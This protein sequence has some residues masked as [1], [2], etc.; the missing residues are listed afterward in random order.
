MSNTQL[1]LK[2]VIQSVNKLTSV[3]KSAQQN[4]RRLADSIR[5][6]RGELK[7]LN[8]TW[9]AIKPYSAPEYAQET[10]QPSSNKE[11][12]RSES[13]YSKVKD[14]RDR[15]SQYG[16]NAKLVGVKIMTTSK[17]FLMPGYDLNAQMSKIQAQTNIE[18]NSPEYAMLLNQSRELS[19]STGVAA[20][21]IA[22]GQSLYASKGYSPDQIKNMMP[23]TVLMSQASGTDFDEVVDISTNVLEGFKLQS[24]EMSHVSDVLTATFTGSKTTLA[25]LG[26]TMKFVAPTA[27]SLGIDIETVAAAIRKLSDTNIQ[28]SEAG[29]ILNSVLERLA[30]PPKVAATALEKLNI[31]TR[32]AKGNLR[33]LP[34]IL[35]ELD[36]KTRSMSSKQ[37]TSYFTAIGGEKAALAL[38]VLVN[39]AGQGGLQA[40]IATLKNVQGESQKVASVM[41]NSLTGDIQKLNAAWSDLGVQTFSGVE[42]PLREVTQQVTNVVNKVSEWMEANPRLAAMLATIT[43]AVGGMLTVFGALAQA[44]ASILLPLAVAKYSLTLFGSTGVRAFGLVGNALKMLGSTMMIVGRLMMANPILAIVGLIS[45]AAVYIWQNWETLGP[46]FSQ[47]WENIK[48]SLNEKWESIKQSALQIWENIKNNISNA[49]EL[50][51]QNTLDIWENIKISISDKWNEIINDVM[52]LPSKFKEVGTAIINSLLE[53][54]NE[55]WEA[56][57]K[58]LTSLSEYIP[59]WM[60]PREDIAKGAGNNMAP[61]VSSVLPKHD[62]GGIIPV[63]GFGI[64]GEYGPEIVTGPVNIISRRQTAKLAAAA[65]FSLSVMASSAAARTAPLHIQSLPVQA[66]PQIQEKTEKRQVHYLS[67]SPVYH[68]NIYGAPEQSAQDIAAMVRREL[69]DRDRKQQAR[70]RSSFSDRGE[71]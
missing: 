58:K 68:I 49:W 13:R 41:T 66:Y 22:Q 40:F 32:D 21:Q 1:Q 67:E 47:L 18:K 71:F 30:E 36:D 31:K 64:V 19:K 45:M 11:E 69:D 42:G 61:N 33:Q 23:G 17:N 29:E 56:L 8:Q 37:R 34:D 9:E 55:K 62:K 10:A 59:D 2:L 39:Q 60:R 44:I 65:A 51:K 35:V 24:E 26:D 52:N 3:L 12:N 53:G 63:G 54:I 25:T 46:K 28:G 7:Q 38:D 70:L 48:I 15:I 6:N 5:Q 43:M 14:L 4:N 50:V 16:A 27:T 20:S 57:K